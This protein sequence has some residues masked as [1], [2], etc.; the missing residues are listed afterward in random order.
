MAADVEWWTRLAG[1]IRAAGRGDVPIDAPLRALR[2]KLGFDCVA[3]IAGGS[4]HGSGAAQTAL[5]NLDYPTETLA[6]I[7]TM[8]GRGCPIHRL[9]VQRGTPMRFAD[10]PF[11]F[12]ETRTYRDAILPNG[13]REGLTLPLPRPAVDVMVPGFVAMSSTN[14]T[15]LD[16]R[17]HLALTMLAHDLAGLTDPGATGDDTAAEVV[18]RVT[19][20][21]IEARAGELDD[22][23]LTRSELHLV[24]QYAAAGTS[25]R[26][27]FRHRAD[28][29]AWWHV[30]AVRRPDAVIVRLGRASLF[31][32][33]TS[34]ELDVVGLVA[35]GWSNERIS[36]A[37][38]V[39]VRTVR[40]HVEASLVKLDCPNRT[41]LARTALEH[42]LDTLDY[43][44]NG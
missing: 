11:D 15:P 19:S 1:E 30:R 24:A 5:V 18:I 32:H 31:G 42:D 17:S 29:G 25:D 28:D 2:D 44:E 33:L 16:D 22:A 20:T 12:R 26:L 9:A 21:L 27:G 37:L 10:V 4:R 23:P 14:A 36:H 6:Y 35:R 13:F 7:T 40:S 39:A 3:L 41:T 43:P 38:G 8:Y 34:R